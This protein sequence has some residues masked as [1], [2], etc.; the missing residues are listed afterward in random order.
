MQIVHSTE[1]IPAATKEE[2]CNDFID[3]SERHLELGETGA[4]LATETVQGIEH[5]GHILTRPHLAL[6]NSGV[7]P[8]AY[9]KQSSPFTLPHFS[10]SPPNSLKKELQF[11]LLFKWQTLP[12][13]WGVLN[14]APRDRCCESNG[15]KG[16]Q[17]E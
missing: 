16:M 12:L 7:R 8:S 3:L 2:I 4:T 15:K 11:F 5:S 10:P 1:E 6:G 13:K 9:Y 17:M 14:F